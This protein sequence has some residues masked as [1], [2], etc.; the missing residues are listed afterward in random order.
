MDCEHF[1]I[2]HSITTIGQ[3]FQ[4]VR[5]TSIFRAIISGSVCTVGAVE[6]GGYTY[7]NAVL[8]QIYKIT[9]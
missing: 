2:D 9:L 1:H 8:C 3:I 7:Q 6:A 4:N 5:L